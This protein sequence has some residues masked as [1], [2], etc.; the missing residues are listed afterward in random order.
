[1]DWLK[2]HGR[3]IGLCGAALGTVGDLLLLSLAGGHIGYSSSTFS[4]LLLIG[5]L[6][7]VVGIS[8]YQFG[9][10][11]RAEGMKQ[12][13][14][15]AAAWLTFSGSMFAATGAAVHGAT[16]LAIALNNRNMLNLNPYEGILQSG[17]LLLGLWVTGAPFFFMAAAA[18]LLICS[19]WKQRLRNPLFVTLVVI[20]FSLLLPPVWANLIG[21][22]SINIAHLIF[23]VGPSRRL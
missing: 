19:N 18:D 4:G 13:H 22:A 6:F 5:T 20:A 23:F 17:A 16:G 21:P 2:T 9:Y 15:R 11:A 3:Q 14:P 8:L 10:R 12:S 1:M 7:G